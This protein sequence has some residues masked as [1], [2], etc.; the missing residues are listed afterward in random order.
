M[1]DT[2]L[3]T[4]AVH[5]KDIAQARDASKRKAGPPWRGGYRQARFNGIVTR[6][7]APTTFAFAANRRFFA[8]GMCFDSSLE[9]NGGP[10]QAVSPIKCEG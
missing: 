10:S 6:R 1:Y 7:K 3:C 2:S 4:C 8:G 9:G 5:K